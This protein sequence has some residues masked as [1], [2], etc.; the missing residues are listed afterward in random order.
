[1]YMYS[2]RPTQPSIYACQPLSPQTGPPGGVYGL[3]ALISR[4]SR[5]IYISLDISKILSAHVSIM[6]TY[7]RIVILESSWESNSCRKLCF[8]VS[9]YRY[10]MACRIKLC[11]LSVFVSALEA[12]NL[13]PRI[14]KLNYYQTPGNTNKSMICYTYRKMYSPGSMVEGRVT[15]QVLFWVGSLFEAHGGFRFAS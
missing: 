6:V 7:T 4:Y 1:M 3:V 11:Q 15:G 13:V 14:Y 12:K 9:S 8:S 5:K 10:L 2:Y